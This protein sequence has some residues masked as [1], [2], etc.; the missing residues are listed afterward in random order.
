MRHSIYTVHLLEKKDQV[1]LEL[2]KD[3][4]SWPAFFIPIPWALFYGMWKVASLFLVLQLSVSIFSGFFST[5]A[6]VSGV[7]FLSLSVVFGFAADEIRRAVLTE[8]GYHFEDIVS[9]RG[10]ESATKFFLDSHPEI[11]RKLLANS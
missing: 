3:G 1:Y 8:C 6:V 5:S 11:A 9:G 7:I 4:F 2:V 10:T